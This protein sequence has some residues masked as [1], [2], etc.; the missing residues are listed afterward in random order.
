MIRLF[1]EIVRDKLTPN[2]LY[3]LMAITE[4]STMPGIVY[5]NE[6]KILE[7]NGFIIDNKISSLGLSLMDK[8]KKLY[9]TEVKGKVKKI[10]DFSPIETEYIYQYRE[11]FPPGILPSGHPSRLSYK[12]LEKRFLTFFNTYK[13]DWSIILKATKAYV[14]K[15]KDS[16]YLYM[17]TSGY[18]IIKN[19]MGV[20]VS[21]LAT[22]C[23][24]IL[25]S[26]TD[27]E[28]EKNNGYTNAI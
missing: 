14:N 20:E 19:E 9:K 25:D 11:I 12:E 15:F 2:G 18:F 16:N 26:P 10:I 23:E 24:M 4:G 5:N 28:N 22:Y 6:K 27:L 3:F 13:Y 1:N 17:K 21:T 8:Y 7:D